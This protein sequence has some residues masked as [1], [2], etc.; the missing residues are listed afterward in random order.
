MRGS[1]KGVL[2][3][4]R[5]C[6]RDKLGVDVC[7]KSNWRSESWEL[8]QGWRIGENRDFMSITYFIVVVVVVG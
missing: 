8:G 4:L 5:G 1:V 7:G 3:V 2:G 6:L